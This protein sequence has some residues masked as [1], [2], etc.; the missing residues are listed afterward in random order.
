[1]T[2]ADVT[3]APLAPDANWGALAREYLQQVKARLFD[4]HRSGASG[5]VIVRRYTAAMD[6]LV[7]RLFEAADGAYAQRFPRLHQPAAIVAQGGY[8]RA[9]LNPC[10]DIDLLFLYQYKR[11]PYIEYVSERILYTLWDTR[12]DVGYAMRNVREC[13]HL[14]NKDLKVKTALLDVRFLCGD[15]PLYGELVTAMEREVLKRGAERFFKEKLAE[16]RERHERFGDSVYLLEPQLKEG[17]G[18]LRDLHTAMW[19]AKVKFKT[20]SVAELV[21]KGVITEREHD[22]LEEAREFLWRVRNALHFLSGKHQDQLTFEYQERI[23]ADLGFRDTPQ[24]KGVE[25]FMRTYYLNAAT[26]NRFADEIIERCT[27]RRRP[28]FGFGRARTR[29]IRPGVVIS[30]GVLTVSGA[31]V[32]RD[33][34]SNLIRIF[35]DAQRHGVPISNSTKRLVRANL[36][37]LDHTQRCTAPMVGA[38]FEVLRGKQRVYESLLDMHRAGVL[39]AFLPEF[40]ALLCMVLH[41]LYHTYTVDEHSL[42]GIHELERLRAGACKTI[43]PM[44][45]QVMRDIDRVDILYL[46]MLLHDIGKGHGGGHSERGARM[47]GQIAERLQ[48]NTDDAA[49]LRFLVARHLNM[50]HL[51]QR[52]DIHDERLIVDFARRVETLDN[53]KMLYLLTFADMRAVGPKIWNNWHDML[54]G[55]LYLRTLEVFEREEFVEEDHAARVERVK[56]RVAAAANGSRDSRALEAFLRDMPDRY[57][58]GTAED[59]ILHHLQLVGN[60][61][62]EPSITEV[63]HYPDRDFSEFTVVT[64]DRPGLFS[65]ITGVLLAHNMNILGASINTSRAGVALDIFRISHG[66]QAESVQRPERWERVQTSLEK[67]LRGEVDVEQLV[68]ASK[69]PTILTRK[70]V[71]RVPTEV[72]VDNEVSDHFTVLD[73]YT[74]DRVGVLFAITNGL[75]HLGLSIHLAKITTNVDQVLDVFYVT[76]DEGK[77][78]LDPERLRRIQD[79]L[80]RRLTEEEPAEDA[81]RAEP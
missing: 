44:L 8:G 72:E 81:Q 47:I 55:E 19:L 21:H 14:A 79:D 75:F 58:L 11:E 65:M 60:L 20:N 42:R 69:R 62:G 80:H 61:D 17:E 39:G 5:T 41:D 63:K 68:A 78:I 34:P 59:S 57:F 73:V 9:E 67:V 66:D 28:Y 4:E 2:P 54:L 71:L 76:D 32:F 13:V 77:K 24:R 53:L 37:V 31:E 10:S 23:A 74:Q 18:G 51:A 25:E 38:F 7:R 29:E 64:R 46:G 43:A 16:S 70:F 6:H 48:L 15:D 33:E 3:L 22:E 1:M 30:Y 27:Q 52:R 12:L 49:Q 26:I 35:G 40:G 50:S 45:T 56:Q 36:D